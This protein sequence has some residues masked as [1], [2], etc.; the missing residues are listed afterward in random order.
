[1]TLATDQLAALIAAISFAAGLKRLCNRC[2]TRSAVPRRRP[3]S[4][5]VAA[6]GR[7]LAGA[8]DLRGHVCGGVPCRQNSRL[9]LD[10]ERAAYFGA[11]PDCGF[12]RLCRR[13]PAFSPG[14]GHQRGCL[15]RDHAGSAR[16]DCLTFSSFFTNHFWVPKLSQLLPPQWLKAAPI[17]FSIAAPMKSRTSALNSSQN[18]T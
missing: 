6:P 18:Q 10:L 15:R 12:A 7:K 4:P 3:R 2:H 11:R 1:M 17:S 8:R 16:R 14:A 9:R 5:A 13:R